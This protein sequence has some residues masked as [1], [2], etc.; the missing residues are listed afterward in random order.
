VVSSERP[1]DAF[2]ERPRR[3][4]VNSGQ[5]A[6]FFKAFRPGASGLVE[7]E[8]K[9]Y[10]KITEA[11]LAPNVRIC[12][13][14]GVVQ[15]EEGLLMGMLLTYVNQQSTLCAAVWPETPT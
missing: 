14:H 9:A 13:L 4:L 12:R 8:L 3:V 15:N 6:C 2:F 10:R 11:E 1:E 5:T 7:T